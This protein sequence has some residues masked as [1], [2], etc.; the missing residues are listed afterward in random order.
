MENKKKKIGFVIGSLSSGG[1][2]RVISTLSNELI[3][4][5]D[6]TIITFTKSS[7]FYSLDDGIKVIHCREQLNQPNSII[8]SLKL[9][10]T[11]VSRISQIIREEKINI[12]IGFITSANILATIAAKLN[13][14]PCIISE[15]NNP[16]IEKVP[17]LWV[18]LRRLVYPLANNLILQTNGIKKIYEKK[19]RPHKITILPNPIST[20]LTEL[21]TNTIKKEKIILSVGRLDK[22]KC[23]DKLIT[24]FNTIAPV[25]W[26][27]IIIGEGAT[28]QK[29]KTLIKSY[30]LIDKIK[31]I[32]KVKNIHEYYNEASIFVFTSKTEGFPNALLEAM[33]YG[34]PCISTDC[35]FGPSDLINDGVNGYLIPVDNQLELTTKLSRLIEDENLQ[36]QFSKTAKESTKKYISKNV[37]DQWESL[38]NKYIK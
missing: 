36:K 15:R 18:I 26:Q 9:N 14:I 24:A 10:Y 35:N 37:L 1:A 30:D 29:L 38:I 13:H 2:E 19:I 6:I 28:K 21:R 8:D 32:S 34:L 4:R 3:Q 23:H 20:D 22:N 25:G 16:L 17:I 31:I 33:H 27:A 7:P 12:I 5:F 11:L